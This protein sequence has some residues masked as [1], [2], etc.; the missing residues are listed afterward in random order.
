M[1][2]HPLKETLKFYS[3]SGYD[4]AQS[5]EHRSAPC[6]ILHFESWEIQIHKEVHTH[7]STGKSEVIIFAALSK[8]RAT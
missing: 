7:C 2:S 8:V 3:F 4:N 1:R 6:S 5:L